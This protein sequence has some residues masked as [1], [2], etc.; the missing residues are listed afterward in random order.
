MPLA[1]KNNLDVLYRKHRL[2]EAEA[3]LL[4]I[5]MG[6]LDPDGPDGDRC[7]ILDIE[8]EAL[9]E[10]AMKLTASISDILDR[11]LQR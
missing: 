9:R 4:E 3:D 8:I 6:A 7:Y 10:Q 2:L 5:Q 1:A 11:D